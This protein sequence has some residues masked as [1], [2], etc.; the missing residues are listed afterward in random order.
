[1][2]DQMHF[3]Q[4]SVSLNHETLRYSNDL[5]G[6]IHH[7]T[8]LCQRFP[9]ASETLKI[10]SVTGHSWMSEM[11]SIIR[12][13]VDVYSHTS[14][15]PSLLSRTWN[16]DSRSRHEKKLLNF[17]IIYMSLSRPQPRPLPTCLRELC[18]QGVGKKLVHLCNSCRYTEI[19]CS[20]TDLNNQSSE[21]IRVNLWFCKYIF[22]GT[23]RGLLTYL[24][25]DL[26]LFSLSNVRRLWYCW[27]ETRKCSAIQLLQAGQNSHP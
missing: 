17:R 23:T 22:Q 10:C 1:M 14:Q 3:L 8:F 25:G 15:W 9:R 5:V 26:E 2:L 19:N 12:V 4:M 13:R 16:P 7:T 21:N 20:I 18:L 24:V 6:Q 11:Y 27:F